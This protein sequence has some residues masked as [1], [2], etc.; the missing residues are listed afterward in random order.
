MQENTTMTV[1]FA[2]MVGSWSV[3]IFVPRRFIAL[4]T[5]LPYLP[6]QLEFGS[7][8]SASLA[9]EEGRRGVAN[10]RP[11]WQKIVANASFVVTGPNLVAS[12][13]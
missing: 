11:A 9:I 2:A 13:S 4:V 10:A 1:I 6:S 3:A 12:I 5:F 8:V 7:A